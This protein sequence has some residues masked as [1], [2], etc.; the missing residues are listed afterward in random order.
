VRS[1]P[2]IGICSTTYGDLI[3][4]G[5]KRFA[6]EIVA[7]NGYSDDQ[8]ERVWRRLYE[9]R[10]A[11]TAVY[12]TVSDATALRHAALQARVERSGTM[13]LLTIGY[14]LLR[15]RAADLVHLHEI[16]LHA[17]RAEPN[18]PVAV[19][20]AIDAEFFVRSVAYFERSF[21]TTVDH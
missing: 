1:T 19:R 15:R 13:S 4:R 18:A 9:L 21:H 20:D 10:D 14:E 16:G 12:V 2:C 3:C 11:A 6:H 17:L 8:R 7:W 5:C